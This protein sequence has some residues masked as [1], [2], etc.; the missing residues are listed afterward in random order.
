M[1][2]DAASTPNSSGLP[3]AG[4][5]P[6]D[7]ASLAH[8][9]IAIAVVQLLYWLLAYP[10]IFSSGQRPHLLDVDRTEVATLNAPTIEAVQAASFKSVALP[11]SDCCAIGYRALRF[12]VTLDA[13]PHDGLAII[14]IAGVDNLALV[15]NGQLARQ[16][17]RMTLPDI[18][19]HGNLKTISFVS[20]GLLH[21][22]D[23]RFEFI[24]VRDSVPYFDINRPLVGR[25]TETRA[26]FEKRNYLLNE[27]QLQSYT[28]A[29]LLA[30]LAVVLCFRSEQKAF[31]VWTL[32][33]VLAWALR[34]HYFRWVDPPFLG[35]VRVFYYFSLTTILPAAWLGVA[36]SWTG[37]PLRW[38][39]AATLVITAIS[40]CVLAYAM[41]VMES[42]GFDLCAS[43]SNAL[44]L[45]F[46]AATI[47]RFVWHLIR[48]RDDR[49]WEV[50]IFMLCITLMAVEF[51]W[52]GLWNI[53]TG[54]LQNS[55]PLLLIAFAVAFFARNV[56]LF[57]SMNEINALL[58]DRLQQR[59]AELAQQYA[60]QGEL[61]R[62]ETLVNERHRLMRD[63]HDGIGGQLLSLLHT[64][65]LQ[66]IPQTDLSESL[67]NVVD[68]LRLIID[69]L[70]SAGNSIGTAL[71]AF[72]RRLEPTLSAA[73]MR[74]IWSN[75]LD[76][77]GADLG[78]REVLQIFRI[79]Q[80]AVT[81]AIRHAQST[82]L[83]I[84]ISAEIGAAAL[85]RVVIADQ[86]RGIKS[87][88]SAGHG[89]K[90]MQARAA[91]IGARL[92]I[93]SGSEGTRI[94]LELP[95]RARPPQGQ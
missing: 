83:Q 61:L 42:G 14:P 44:G 12:N 23:N 17:G 9:L 46:G 85:L 36:D 19:Y 51:I 1:T 35:D 92:N 47:A 75:T 77:E 78:P 58:G 27:Y 87:R 71:A 16:E 30:L 13:V 86:G 4:P 2:A 43:L 84:A 91:S 65:R 72:R 32:V 95:L 67:S 45:L 25:Y 64:S 6:P 22:G 74:L 24:M 3:S 68:E 73:G 90:N 10:A 37:R 94:T 40:L 62:R 34:M 69:S 88:A 49:H 54:H 20:P 8:A 7:K 18:T 26:L 31:A 60:R 39:S 52:Q 48:V 11:W 76:E 5:A 80:E 21:S 28:V 63:M 41:F 15:V 38:L 29:F 55:L 59:E 89:L 93:E 50:A 53:S 66:P 33:L 79:V 81:N 57:R 70:D 82:T 56:R